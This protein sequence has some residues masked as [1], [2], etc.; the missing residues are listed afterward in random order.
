M[1]DPADDPPEQPG[2]LAALLAIERLAT[3]TA[4]LAAKQ[5]ADPRQAVEDLR[6]EALRNAFNPALGPL[7]DQVH[8]ALEEM[9]AHVE[10]AA[11]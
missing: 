2:P 10:T 11:A 3:A 5:A 7:V 4:I 6:D 9:L 8:T 1:Y